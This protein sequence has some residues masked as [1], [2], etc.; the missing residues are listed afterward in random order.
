[1]KCKGKFINILTVLLL[2]FVAI[3][4]SWTAMDNAVTHKELERNVFNCLPQSAPAMPSEMLSVR[5]SE[6]SQT[7]E[8]LA[9]LFQILFILFIISPPLIVLM[10]FLIWKELKE[11]NR[12]K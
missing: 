8:P 10:L 11:R 9:Y 1:M 6:I 12:L 3:N 2:G 5:L 4:L 7:S